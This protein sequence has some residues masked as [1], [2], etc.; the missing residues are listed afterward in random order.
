MSNINQLLR[1]AFEEFATTIETDARKILADEGL[2]KV[3][4]Q[5]E[6]TDTAFGVS[7]EFSLSGLNPY[8]EY[9]VK[10]VFYTRKGAE[11]SPFQYKHLGPSEKMIDNILS[12][13]LKK[14]IF[15]KPKKA[16]LKN[17]QPKEETSKTIYDRQIALT[18][19]IARNV[20]KR[21][22]APKGVLTQLFTEDRLKE[23]SEKV[24]DIVGRE[25]TIQVAKL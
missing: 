13:T 9:G 11:N 8:I 3:I 10:G 20:K 5:T 19:A 16:S 25:I 17:N 23:L 22:I 4:P 14:G 6:I 15:A 24:S 1:Q 2:E 7:Y 18:F 12:W 21:G